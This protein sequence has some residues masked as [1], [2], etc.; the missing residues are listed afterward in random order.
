M[1]SQVSLGFAFLLMLVGVT[2]ALTGCLDLIFGPSVPNPGGE[3]GGDSEPHQLETP[4]E[5]ALEAAT[6]NYVEISWQSDALQHRVEW[7][8]VSDPTV[9]GYR[10]FDNHITN[11]FITD[12]DY[13]A[14]YKF[15]V[16]AI[17]DDESASDSEW[18]GYIHATTEAAPVYTSSYSPTEDSFIDY[19]Y[20][21]NAY[22][23][24]ELLCLGATNIFEVNS[25]P[26]EIHAIMR[27]EIP[28]YSDRDVSSATLRLS[29]FSNED[30]VE[31]TFHVDWAQTADEWDE[32]TVNAFDSI[33]GPGQRIYD[34]EIVVESGDGALPLDVTS[35]FIWSESIAHGFTL[36][37]EAEWAEMDGST[38]TG[39]IAVASRNN[40]YGR[41]E[42]EIVSSPKN[43]SELQ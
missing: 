4:G 10:D 33:V 7:T 41:P 15:R 21:G 39:P 38:Y 13:D 43:P 42:L 6:Q 32:A 29:A 28:D 34:N 27:F 5:L 17:S 12:L 19:G 23:T 40:T 9:D 8:K 31:A 36:V 25:T 2:V 14:E 18:S 3:T 30:G 11:V 35:L 20:P 37:I 22:G 26:R 1:R 24:A 16:K